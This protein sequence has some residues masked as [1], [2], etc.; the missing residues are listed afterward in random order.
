MIRGLEQL[1]HEERLSVLELFSLKK[2]RLRRDLINVHKYLKGE[3]QVY[4]A[5]LF[6]V[7]PSNRKRDNGHRLEHRKFCTNTR[8]NVFTVRMTGLE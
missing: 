5:R 4:E 3:C 2:V 6:L 7:M 1:P 8:K